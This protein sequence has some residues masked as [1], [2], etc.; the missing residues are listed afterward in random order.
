[1]PHQLLT[2][3]TRRL[4]RVIV[5]QGHANLLCVV[6]CVSSARIEATALQMTRQ[7]HLYGVANQTTGP[8]ALTAR[9]RSVS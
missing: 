9:E 5:A 2:S 4:M 8:L 3:Q 1:L 6:L 7:P